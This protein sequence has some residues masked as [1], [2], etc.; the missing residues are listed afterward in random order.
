MPEKLLTMAG[1]VAEQCLCQ[2][3][4]YDYV[5]ASSVLLTGVVGL[6]LAM[7]F[8]T[9]KQLKMLRDSVRMARDRT[10]QVWVILEHHISE[11][12]DEH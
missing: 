12:D 7:H 1:K 4:R 11:D 5:V 10:E 2:P 9:R 6:L 3:P 8:G